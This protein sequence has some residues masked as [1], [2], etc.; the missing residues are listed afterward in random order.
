MNSA[1]LDYV[2]NAF[3][4]NGL[5]GHFYFVEIYFGKLLARDG[6]DDLKAIMHGIRLIQ[7]DRKRSST[8]ITHPSLL[9]LH[10]LERVEWCILLIMNAAA[11]L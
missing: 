1:L 3:T 11:S 10:G 7:V 4:S 2:G 5:K 9:T 8:T 6:D